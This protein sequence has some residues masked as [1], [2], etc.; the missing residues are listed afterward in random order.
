MNTV[1]RDT[2]PEK[3]V[4][5]NVKLNHSY[6]RALF[7]TGAVASFLGKNI[8]KEVCDEKPKLYEVN[9]RYRM[10]NGTKLT[11]QQEAG[12]D[13]E[14]KEKSHSVSFGILEEMTGPMK[15]FLAIRT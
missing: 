14:Y 2:N 10:L 12:A 6:Y 15:L 5:D 3:M 1:Q 8:S 4:Y 7:D 11:V 13:V 9:R